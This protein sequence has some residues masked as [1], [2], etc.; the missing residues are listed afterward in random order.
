MA[1]VNARGCHE[2]AS[3]T[4]ERADVDG[5]RRR[6]RLVV[7]S[8]GA[9]L[10]SDSYW[11]QYSDSGYWSGNSLYLFQQRTRE[12]IPQLLTELRNRAAKYEN[13][14]SMKVVTRRGI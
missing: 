6:T 2:V 10:R 14:A 9:V 1:K 4:T 13:G 5:V 12:D 7:R 3:L 8:D 11:A